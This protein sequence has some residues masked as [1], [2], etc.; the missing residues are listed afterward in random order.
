MSDLWG[1]LSL[2]PSTSCVFSE[3]FGWSAFRLVLGFAL[4]EEGSLAARRVG[5]GKTDGVGLRVGLG[6]G[7]GIGEGVGVGVGMRVGVG[8]ILN[9]KPFSL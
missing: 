5:D 2:T 8:E 4:G 1:A 3:D 9:H 7:V 6:I